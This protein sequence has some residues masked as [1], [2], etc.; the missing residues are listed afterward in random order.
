MNQN[1]DLIFLIVVLVITV[2]VLLFAELVLYPNE[3]DKLKKRNKALEKELKR[4]KRE[5]Y[6]PVSVASLIIL[7]TSVMRSS[8]KRERIDM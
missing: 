6:S 2:I 7:M 3:I 8:S 5:S 4:L 1:A